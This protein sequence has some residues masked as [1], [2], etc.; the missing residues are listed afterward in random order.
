[1]I[2]T[3]GRYALRMMIDLAHHRGEG[4]IALKDIAERQ[5]ISKKYLEQIIPVL[6]RAGL[7]ITSR[8]FGG[9]YKLNKSPAEYTVGEIL[10]ATE[11]NMAPVACLE[12]EKNT[13]PRADRCEILSVWKGLNEVVNK[14]LDSITL[15][16][17]LSK[18]GNYGDNYCI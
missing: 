4:F 3:R 11:G 7:L 2:S 16:D 1:M 9:G 18:N 17:I 10:R 5:D 15:E 14:Y 13:C 6:N 12:N 8:G